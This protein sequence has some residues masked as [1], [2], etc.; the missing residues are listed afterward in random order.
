MPTSAGGLHYYRAWPEYNCIVGA[1]ILGKNP[2]ECI[3]AFGY[4]GK[5][6]LKAGKDIPRV[7]QAAAIG[8]KRNFCYVSTG[9]SRELRGIENLLIMHTCS[10]S[11]ERLVNSP[12][13]LPV[14]QV[15]G[16]YNID[17]SLA[18]YGS[19]SCEK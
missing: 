7:A 11:S 16:N 3:G 9:D 12:I 2:A 8:P 1:N 17:Q 15:V 10:R 5:V 4:C 18:N 13:S 19:K 6:D 14:G